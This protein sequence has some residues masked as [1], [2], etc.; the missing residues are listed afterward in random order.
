MR[1][2]AKKP[3]KSLGS[4]VQHA[5]MVTKRPVV[6]RIYTQPKRARESPE[7]V[8]TGSDDSKD[9][10]AEQEPVAK[11]IQKL[12]KK[13]PKSPKLANRDPEDSDDDDEEKTPVVKKAPK[14]AGLVKTDT[15]LRELR[16]RIYPKGHGLSY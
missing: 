15:E 2:E 6:K 10:D 4:M 3:T 5:E 12:T 13:A 7:F 14:S 11:R 9:D 1:D 8:E 16:H